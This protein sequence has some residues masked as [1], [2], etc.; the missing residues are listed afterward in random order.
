MKLVQGLRWAARLGSLATVAFV[1]AFA[2][3]GHESAVPTASEWVGL[4]LF[5]IGVLAG[6]LVAW[7]REALGGLVALG[8]L[9]LFYVWA[10]FRSGHPPG[11]PYFALL[12]S[13]ALLFLA[14]AVLEKK[15][16]T[17]VP[18]RIG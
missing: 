4:S 18:L 17:A 13:P 2:F 14:A 12:T 1:A 8:S 7:R 9:L 5:P 15:Q 16:R 3:G 6:L 11:G 10:T